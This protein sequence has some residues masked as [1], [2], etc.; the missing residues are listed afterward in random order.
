MADNL[1]TLVDALL[2]ADIRNDFQVSQIINAAPFAAALPTVISKT[3]S[4]YEFLKVT[5]APEVVF[6]EVNSGKDYS[7]STKEKKTI[8]LKYLDGDVEMDIAAAKVGGDPTGAIMGEAQLSLEQ[9]FFQLESQAINGTF[10]ESNGYQGFANELSTLANPM[11]VDGGGSGSN[12]FSSV[13][14]VNVGPRS[15]FAVTT[16]AVQGLGDIYRCKIKDESGK[17]LSGIAMDC[18]GYGGVA[19]A[20][21]FDVARI[22]N[23]TATNG[24]SDALIANAY[25]RMKPGHKP[26]HILMNSNQV[27]ALQQSRATDLITS[28]EWPTES[29]GIKILEVNSI[30]DTEAEI[31]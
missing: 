6:R 14:L 19:I 15:V 24:V 18:N 21:N 31:V 13:Y 9:F 17:T 10:N 30:T 8:T 25:K 27:Y 12:E 29:M 26:T 4:V 20:T 22:C 16:G 11:V 28:P 1:K 5:A 23:L 2:E 3:G 7:K